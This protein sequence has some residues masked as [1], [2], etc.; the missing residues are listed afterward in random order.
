MDWKLA[1]LR[2]RDDGNKKGAPEPERSLEDGT[3]RT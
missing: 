1:K 3:D 2:A